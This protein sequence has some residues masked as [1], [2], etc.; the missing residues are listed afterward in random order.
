[1]QTA[2]M[3]S[4]SPF[5]ELFSD[6]P[7]SLPKRG[8]VINQLNDAITFRGFMVKGSL[9]LLERTTPDAMGGRFVMLEYSSI[10]AVKMIDPLK[11]E[12]FAPVGFEGSLGIS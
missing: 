7:A 9:L 11:T 2:A 12:H 5:Q 10:A 8:I 4:V 1:M 6:W 3:P